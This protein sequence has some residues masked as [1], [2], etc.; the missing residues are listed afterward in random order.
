MIDIMRMI[1]LE[2]RQEVNIAVAILIDI[3]VIWMIYNLVIV[4]TIL[5]ME[6][7]DAIIS[8]MKSGSNK[9]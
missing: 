1:L 5:K 8:R 7:T 9:D 4:I 3:V 6:F 2:R